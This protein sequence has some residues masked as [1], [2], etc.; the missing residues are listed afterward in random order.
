MKEIW[1]KIGV[2]LDFSIQ[3]RLILLGFFSD[4]SNRISFLNELISYIA[5]KI[6]KYKMTCR[7]NKK[8]EDKLDLMF[9]NE[10]CF[11]RL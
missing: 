4:S 6:Y 5:F 8:R 11:I 1:Y 10:K 9:Y 2:K 3:W 7:Y